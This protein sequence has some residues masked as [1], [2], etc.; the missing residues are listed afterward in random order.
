MM[1]SGLRCG[2]QGRRADARANG[3]NGIDTVDV[4]DG[5]RTLSVILFGKAPAG[6]APANFRLDG[7]TPVTVTDLRPC[8]EQDPDLPDCLQLSVDRPGD[9][10]CY[11]LSVVAAGPD[12]RPGTDPYP[13]F[14]A[15]CYYA[16]FSFKQNCGGLGDCAP[17]CATASTPAAEPVI[18][19]LARDYAS[20][21]QAL[22]D[23]LSLTMP[24]W[25]ERHLPDVGIALAELLA[26]AGDLLNY[27][28]DAVGTEAYL[29]TARLR[30]SVRRHAR[31]V[32]YRMHDGCAARAYVCL[33][34]SETI[35]LPAGGF[36]FSAGTEIFEPLVTE[37]VTLY[38][39]HR[40]ISLWTWGDH[41]CCLPA[42]ATAA[43]LA[44]S[45]LHLAVGDL[46][47]FEEIAGAVTG[48]AADADKTHRQVVRLTSV[49]PGR[50]AL[51]DQPVLEV[52][53]DRADA[54][55]FPLCVTARGG[56]D[57]V[58]FPVGVA[59]GNVVLVEHGASSDWDGGDGDQVTLPSAPPSPGRGCPPGCG[60]GCPDDEP[61]DTPAYPP[62]RYK[63]Q[64]RVA[65]SPVTQHVAF[66]EPS[67]VARAQAAALAGIP[68]LA[69]A[70]ISAML[71]EATLT[72]DDTAYLTTLFGADVLAGY[73][74]ATAPAM[75]LKLLLARFDE[76]LAVKLARLAHLALRAREGYVLS[77]TDEGTELDGAWGPGTGQLID[78]ARPAFRGPAAA[79]LT[80]DPRDAMPA[81][82]A[83]DDTGEDPWLPRRDLLRCGPADRFFVGETDDDGTLT[84]RFGDGVA[85]ARPAPGTTLLLRDRLGNGTAG[86][87]GAE[88]I[89]TYSLRG[90]NQAAI[91][92]VRNPLPAAGGVDP[93][94]VPIVRQ[95][96]PRAFAQVLRRAITADDYARLAGQHTGVQ[97]AGAQ[98]R[99]TGSWYEAQ[100]AVDALGAETAPCWLLGDELRLLQRYAR[101]GHDVR[102]SSAVLVPV[103]LALCVRV[104]PGYIAA[105]VKAAI[106]RRLGRGVL[107]D[108]TL[109]MFH[110]DSLTFGTPIRVSVIVAAVTAVAGVAGAAVTVLKRQFAPD[111]GAVAAGV[112]TFAP[113]EVP[114]LDSDPAHPDRGQLCLT[115]GGGR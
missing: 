55:A 15:R 9:F 57:C 86:N 19:Y 71:G 68:A 29:D 34:V 83:S 48:L 53:W 10:S 72:G 106:A 31:L 47:V 22:L 36:R 59:R 24:G 56:P 65:H 95:R 33:T 70:R 102:V 81:I 21:R 11:R 75:A 1:T 61:A 69:R 50:D 20:L 113:D 23:R 66:P 46:L 62:F 115:V 64:V 2:D 41:Q 42:G 43:T 32:D 8:P 97:R 109:A 99:W 73:P 6:L 104:Q 25:T 92:L 13:G 26:Y 51:Y 114:Q 49:T 27:R 107:P 101:I 37:D 105:D 63:P 60:W 14:D 18:D 89:N 52:T 78:P 44:D 3:L 58:N 82:S 88:A 74:L 96:A 85:G 91:T 103:E 54:L 100:V 110:P 84:L 94:P 39:V 76:L 5:Q 16:D 87:V 4:S 40:E 17:Q 12:G 77:V 90:V 108:G 28:L 98:L 79:A 45:G 93:E 67:R 80:P 35:T 7:G 111:E 30:T 112:L 38:A